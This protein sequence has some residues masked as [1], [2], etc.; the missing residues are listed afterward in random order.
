[1]EGTWKEAVVN[2]FKGMSIT[3]ILNSKLHK[4]S[5]KKREECGVPDCNAVKIGQILAPA[6]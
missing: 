1:L 2:Y 4:E 5:D 3:A 6:S